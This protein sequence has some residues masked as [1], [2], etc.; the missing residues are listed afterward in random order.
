[1]VP[2]PPDPSDAQEAAAQTPCPETD[3]RTSVRGWRRRQRRRPLAVLPQQGDTACARGVH[4]PAR[5]AAQRRHPDHEEPAH[6]RRAARTRPDEA[7][8]RAD[9]RGRRRWHGAVRSDDEARRCLRRALHQHGARRRS[10]WCAGGDPEPPER[11]PRAE[12][13]DQVQGEGGA[14]L[15]DCDHDGCGP[16]ARPRVHVRDPEVQV[17]VREHGPE[18]RHALDHRDRDRHRRTHAGVV[19]DLRGRH[20]AAH[21]AAS[22]A[23]SSSPMVTAASCTSLP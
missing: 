17:G 5:G 20:P 6:S 21:R 16:R 1:M 2:A 4:E 3:R 23:C 22:P 13:V 8:C 14:G 7:G 11:L 15:P 12:R 10:G 18:G 9:R 19:V